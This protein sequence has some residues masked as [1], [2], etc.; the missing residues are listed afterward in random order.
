MI[1]MWMQ[2]QVEV[3]EVEGFVFLPNVSSTIISAFFVRH[4]KKKNGNKKIGF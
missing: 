2:D 1:V 3:K 4:H